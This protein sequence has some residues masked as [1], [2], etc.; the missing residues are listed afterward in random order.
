LDLGFLILDFGFWIL[1][2]TKSAKGIFLTT[3]IAKG[4]FFTTK[5]AKDFLLGSWDLGEEPGLEAQ[6][7][8]P[9]PVPQGTDPLKPPVQTTDIVWD[10][11]RTP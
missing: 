6:G 7:T 2:T 10:L 11:V 1:L 3:K 8:R 9:M 5:S 4:K